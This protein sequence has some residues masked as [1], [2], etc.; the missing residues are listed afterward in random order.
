MTTSKNQIGCFNQENVSKAR[1]Q[2]LG[3]QYPLLLLLHNEATHQRLNDTNKQAS[4]VRNPAAPTRKYGRHGDHAHTIDDTVWCPSKTQMNNTTT[5][6]LKHNEQSHNSH[7]QPSTRKRNEGSNNLPKK[8][9]ILPIRDRY[10]TCIDE[11][12][13]KAFPPPSLYHFFL[14]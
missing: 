14:V 4:S 7:P 6:P 9:I 10:E 2:R 3:W 13:G 5:V 8:I 12:A 11:K 1:C